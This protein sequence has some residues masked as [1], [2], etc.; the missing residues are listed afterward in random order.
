MTAVQVDP[1]QSLVN[2]TF[3]NHTVQDEQASKQHLYEIAKKLE[4]PGRSTMS[5]DQLMDAIRKANRSKTRA[6][7]PSSR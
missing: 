6:K 4:I 7:Q 2:V 3:R 1:K 5:R